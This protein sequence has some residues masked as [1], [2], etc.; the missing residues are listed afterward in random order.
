MKSGTVTK[1]PAMKLR[2]SHCMAGGSAVRRAEH[3]HREAAGA[4]TP[5]PAVHPQSRA[6]RYD[7]CRF[8][9]GRE[10]DPRDADGR[11]ADGRS[12]AAPAPT[13]A[14]P[15]A[16]ELATIAAAD[17]RPFQNVTTVPA[18]NTLE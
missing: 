8:R 9:C 16:A 7:T 4:G 13:G 17:P 15:F 2:R 6:T 1:K 18:M 10:R 11:D 14:P 3:S 12:A 5:A